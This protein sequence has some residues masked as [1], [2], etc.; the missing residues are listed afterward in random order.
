MIYINVNNQRRE[1]NLKLVEEMKQIEIRPKIRWKQQSS[2]LYKINTLA[3]YTLVIDEYK[4]IF[5]F[6]TANEKEENANKIFYL[7]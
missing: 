7:L 2:N 4:F 5:H 3:F 1:N 6:I